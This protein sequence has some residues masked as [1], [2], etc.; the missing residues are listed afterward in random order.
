MSHK[1]SS[2]LADIPADKIKAGAFRVLFH[3]CDA[4]NSKRDAD[5][6]CFPS[7]ASL[8]RVTGLSNGGLNNA[9]NDLE[10]ANLIARRRTRNQD[11]TKGPTYYILGCDREI[12][13]E[14]T[15]ENG[16]GTIS[17]S[18]PQPSPN[19]GPNHLQPTGDKP[20]R[21]P[22]KEPVSAQ[23]REIDLFSDNDQPAEAAP[24][25]EDRFPDFYEAYPRKIARGNAEKAW[26]KAVKSAL[27]QE[28]IDGA[29]RYAALCRQKGTEAQFIAHPATWLN[30]Q[31]WAD[32]ELRGVRLPEEITPQDRAAKFR[33]PSWQ[34]VIS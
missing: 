17:K 30:A 10:K 1:A 6:A 26:A 27:P 32:E 18:G 31:R 4:H 23:A 25:P 28:I 29:R 20:V 9:L 33:P 16:V 5:T 24:K 34:T 12:S 11:G 7:Q 3:L 8:M 22:V 19:Q 2:W 13:N 15:P 14:Q 21:E